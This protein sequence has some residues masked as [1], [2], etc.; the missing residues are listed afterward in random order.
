MAEIAPFL[1]ER[2]ASRLL[3]S[4]SENGQDLLSAIEPVLANFL[5][6]KAAGELVGHLLDTAMGSA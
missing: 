1:G 5:G 2:A 6:D 3:R 4:V